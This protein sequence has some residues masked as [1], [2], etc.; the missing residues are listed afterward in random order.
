M[1]KNVRNA[2]SVSQFNTFKLGM[3][4]VSIKIRWYDICGKLKKIRQNVEVYNICMPGQFAEFFNSH[5]IYQK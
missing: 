5:E 3:R 4:Y 2:I 1:W